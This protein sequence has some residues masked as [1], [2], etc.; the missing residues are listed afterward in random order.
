MPPKY[1][2]YAIFDQPLAIAVQ[3]G[4]VD[5]PTRFRR[6]ETLAGA[7]SCCRVAVALLWRLFLAK[8]EL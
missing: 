6:S 7:I 2:T 5:M 1:A 8:P 4:R 3:N